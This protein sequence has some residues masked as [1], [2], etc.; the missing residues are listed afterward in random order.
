[1]LQAFVDGGGFVCGVFRPLGTGFDP[2]LDRRDLWRRERLAFRRHALVVVA[3]D[4]LE[5]RRL[6]EF[7]R[8]DSG[9]VVAAFEGEELGVETQLAFLLF[10]TVALDAAVLEQRSDFAVEVRGE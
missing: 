8:D 10:L 6:V 4:A 9:A 7:A 3:A 5:E 1:M 2:R